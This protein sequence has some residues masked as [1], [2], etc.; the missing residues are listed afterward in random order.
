MF[1]KRCTPY[2]AA[3]LVFL[4]VNL[5][6]SC[7]T[8]RPFGIENGA[9]VEKGGKTVVPIEKRAIV[10]PIAGDD[11][12]LLEGVTVSDTRLE[13]TN[14][15]KTTAA[16]AAEKV[17]DIV[18]LYLL[19]DRPVTPVEGQPLS[20]NVADIDRAEIREY[21]AAGTVLLVIGISV[22][23]A[24]GILAI[25]TLIALA[26]KS[27]CPFVY[28]NDAGAYRMAGEI[29]SGAVFPDQERDD[30]LLLP[31]RSATGG[32]YEVQ[33]VNAVRNETQY[34]NL[35]ELVVCDHPAGTAVLL[36]K[37]GAP[38]TLRDVWAPVSAQ[39]GSGRSILNEVSGQDD[40]RT[41][42]ST[43]ESENDLTDPLVCVFR[44]PA[45]AEEA[46]LVVRAKN[47]FW[48]EYVYK[49]FWYLFGD[50]YQPWVEGKIASTA[51]PGNW[52]DL[53]HI[54]LA[55]SKRG[56]GAWRA[57]D[58]YPIAGPIAFR[59]YVMSVDLSDVPAG[60]TVAVKLESGRGFWEIDSIGMDFSSDAEVRQTRLAAESALDQNG[61][62]LA[63][64]LARPDGEYYVQARYRDEGR[65]RFSAPP[66][67]QAESA[68][69]ARTV[70]LHS[71]GY[72]LVR[73][74]PPPS[75]TPDLALLS[76]MNREG[77]FNRFSN[78][79]YLSLQEKLKT[80]GTP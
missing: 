20:I 39:N 15:R 72:Y 33:I 48:L 16:K 61:R 22:G 6:V 26:T 64:S 44:R 40:G 7:Y 10:I 54:T 11:V 52:K 24:V 76:R 70:F 32:A 77:E 17:E 13:S 57:V 50:R 56:N 31:V 69:P 21:N 65:L 79:L 47:T 42:V 28:V 29:Y 19:K 74:D 37:Y 46:K 80:A 59:D 8:T 14:V 63:A 53:Q 55:V 5:M 71:R 35:A 62:D 1:P 75:G 9:F 60:E 58:A 2:C 78:R 25:I 12:W 68:S 38:H 27:S 3:V 23:A 43:V 4:T 51:A 30:Y 41:Y 36:D 18:F 45:G 73:L 34:T 49:Q 67:A 66:I